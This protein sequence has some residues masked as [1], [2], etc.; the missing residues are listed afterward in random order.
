M[1]EVYIHEIDT[2]KLLAVTYV[3]DAVSL[4]AK[5]DIIHPHSSDE[6][7]FLHRIPRESLSRTRSLGEIE[8]QGT[9]GSGTKD[10]TTLLMGKQRKK[11][12]DMPLADSTQHI[13]TSPSSPGGTILMR[14]AKNS[15]ARMIYLK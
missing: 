12:V 13:T 6:L 1:D 3:F 5:L 10:G 14:R 9:Y 4:T 11:L 15:T 8:E 2:T 7:I